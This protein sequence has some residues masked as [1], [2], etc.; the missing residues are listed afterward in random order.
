MANIENKIVDR[1]QH[2]E[3]KDIF[4]AE[5]PEVGSFDMETVHTMLSDMGT[6][7]DP[8]DLLNSML[9][10]LEGE[11][12]KAALAAVGAIPVVGSLKFLK[13]PLETIKK[14]FKGV[15]K[16]NPEEQQKFF[17]HYMNVIRQEK[18]FYGDMRPGSSNWKHQA[19]ERMENI[20]KEGVG[21]VADLFP[22]SESYKESVKHIM[23]NYAKIIN[24]SDV[25]KAGSWSEDAR[26]SLEDVMLNLD[27]LM[28]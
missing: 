4:V 14:F 24:P 15:K 20:N 27:D 10:L 7:V 12:G 18:K 2:E 11:G 5:I 3:N 6:L 19:L 13:K 26:K 16:A 8:A 25:R 1:W 21:N 17:N 9:Y 23:D 28:K 22:K